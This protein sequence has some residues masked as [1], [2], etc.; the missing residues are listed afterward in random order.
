MSYEER[1]TWVYLV[2]SAGVYAI[3]L[4]VVLAQAADPLTDTAYQAPLLWSIGA[5]IVA[6]IIVRMVVEIGA[7]ARRGR[8]STDPFRADDRDRE[9]DRLGTL[10]TWWVLIAAAILALLMALAEWPHFWIANV[11]YLG[12]VAQAVSSA[13]VKLVAY[14]RGL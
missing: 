9:I 4:A 1:G 7:G 10:R 12:F 5:A 14:R 11:I 13:V 3:Y 8:G 2:V 6:A